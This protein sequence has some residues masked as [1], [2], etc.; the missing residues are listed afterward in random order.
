MMKNMVAIAAVALSLSACAK[1]TT[2]YEAATSSNVPAKTIYVAANA[3]N[4]VKTTATGYIQY[5]TP[6]PTPAGCNDDA[7]EN[8]IIPSIDKGTT[9]RN[10]LTT[11]IKDHPGEL[12]DKGVYDGLVAATSSLQT[13]LATYDKRN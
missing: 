13:L 3:F 10:T 1:L 5:C 6:N 2:V 9:A 8:K 4:V 7:I 12:G 11:F